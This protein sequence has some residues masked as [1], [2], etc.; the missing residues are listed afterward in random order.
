[1]KTNAAYGTL[2]C[3]ARESIS[4]YRRVYREFTNQ[5]FS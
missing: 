1:M 5:Y 4:L 2:Y 3:E